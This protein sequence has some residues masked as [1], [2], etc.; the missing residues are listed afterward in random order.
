MRIM[1]NYIIPIC[2][3][4]SPGGALNLL[5]LKDGDKTEGSNK[6]NDLPLLTC[7]ASRHI[8]TH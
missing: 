5:R 3:L 2:T 7:P 4:C 6:I 8:L 1:Y